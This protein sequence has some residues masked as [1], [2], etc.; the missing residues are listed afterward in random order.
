MTPG[1]HPQDHEGR[2]VSE[3]SF[4]DVAFEQQIRRRAWKFYDVA[5]GAYE[6]YGVLIRNAVS[7]GSR[8]L[9]YGCGPGSAAFGLARMG[10]DVDGIDIS[11]VAI[12]LAREA[13]QR[14]GVADHATFAVMDAEQLEFPDQS[15]DLVCG[16]SIIH[17]LDV[18]RAFSEVARVLR[19]GGTAVFL[20][21]LGHNP[22]INA[23]RRLTPA[24]RTADSIP[25]A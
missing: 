18:K 14:D 1:Q 25:C 22:A 8:A 19:P 2:L 4:H 16:T 17:H 20:E 7:E 12:S 15:F 6:R 3:A 24:L 10:V 11:P 23:Y 9:E 21:A 13:A 5:S